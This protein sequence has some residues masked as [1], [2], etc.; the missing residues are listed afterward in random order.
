[1][2]NV[3]YYYNLAMSYD[4]SI[5]TFRYDAVHDYDIARQAFTKNFDD[6]KTASRTSSQDQIEALLSETYLTTKALAG[7]VKNSS[8][9]LDQVSNILNARRVSV[10][11]AMAGQK[12]D[13]ASFTGTTNSHLLDL[14][15]T[16]NTIKTSRQQIPDLQ[17]SIDEKQASLEKIQSGSD[18]LDLQSAQLSIKQRENA[19][20]DAQEKLADYSVRA[21][22]DGTI[23]KVLVKKSDQ[24]SSGATVATLIT[25]E[26][27]A[28]ISLNEIDAAKV[29][30]GQKATL[31]FDA[32]DG[33]SITGQ[34]SSLDAIGT[35]SQGVVTYSAKISFDTQ[36][37]RIKSG[38]SISAAIITQ[39]R[40][41][42]I[43][44]PN[45]AVKSDSNG[46]HYVEIFDQPLANSGSTQGA[47]SPVPPQQQ[48]VEVGLSN[49]T[50]TE[51]TSGLTEGQQ[52]VVRTILP[53]AAKTSQQAPSLFG[54]VGARAGGQGGATRIQ[55]QQ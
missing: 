20:T 16:I 4:L 5:G 37:V 14:L 43:A 49:D 34:V 3:D 2:D 39:M 28:E 21:P 17:R 52:I 12:S 9:F 23:T 19:L 55:R 31:T 24:L 27:I 26:N 1:M 7:A 35:V 29:Q 13:L 22:F 36:D 45:A 42:V 46:G 50:L 40:Q 51:I 48:T 18:V 54:S 33:L 10:P 41:D 47:V 6:Y 30:V 25:P 32:I 53:T 38:M 44:V 15:N 8:N 11:T